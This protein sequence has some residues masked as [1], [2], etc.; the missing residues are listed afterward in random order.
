MTTWLDNLIPLKSR[1]NHLQLAGWKPS[2]VA[3]QDLGCR[4]LPMS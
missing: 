2:K 4:C 3:A 1:L